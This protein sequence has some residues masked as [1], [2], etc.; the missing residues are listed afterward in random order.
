MLLVER[1]AGAQ[2]RHDAGDLGRREPE[3]KRPGEE[4]DPE[5]FGVVVGHRE[6]PRSVAE[7]GCDADRNRVGAV[8]DRRSPFDA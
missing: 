2:Q 7:V 3:S 8:R 1:A 5:R 6:Q 4:R